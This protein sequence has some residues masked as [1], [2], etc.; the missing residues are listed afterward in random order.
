MDE[1]INKLLD[2]TKDLF[3]AARNGDLD[4]IGDALKRR[5]T[6]IATL[7]SMGGLTPHRTAS[8]EAVIEQIFEYDKKSRAKLKELFD[9]HGKEVSNFTKK[10]DGLMKY[11]TGQYNLMSGQL[12]DKRD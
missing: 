12:F 9:R 2:E 10:A 6:T 5:E 8:Q 7:K 3:N 1:L 11:N 4:K